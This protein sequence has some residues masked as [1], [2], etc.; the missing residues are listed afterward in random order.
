MTPSKLPDIIILGGIKLERQYTVK[1]CCG[2]PSYP[3]YPKRQS[4]NN[5]ECNNHWNK[6]R[7]R[8]KK[9]QFT[10][11]GPLKEYWGSPG[12]WFDTPSEAYDAFIKHQLVMLREK[13]EA[14]QL[15][16]FKAI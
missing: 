1:N 12:S 8:K 13:Y 5:W 6:L 3:P 7:Y 10:G 16:L 11:G 15:M 9:W 14:Q 4:R 2:S